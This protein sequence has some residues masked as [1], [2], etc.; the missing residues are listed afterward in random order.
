M[1]IKGKYL[2]KAENEILKEVVK[3]GFEPQ[4]FSDRAGYIYQPHKHNETK[5]LVFL[6]GEMEVMVDGKKFICQKGDEL[7]IPS[8]KTHSAIVGDN[9]CTFF[10][11]EKLI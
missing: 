5:L 7:I 10:W 4:K 9:G 1:Y 6:D 2:N 3:L 8:D 11:S